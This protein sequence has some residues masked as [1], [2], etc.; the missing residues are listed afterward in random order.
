MTTDYI[1][2]KKRK[3]RTFFLKVVKQQNNVPRNQPANYLRSFSLK[4]VACSF[5]SITSLVSSWIWSVSSFLSD[6]SFSIR[7]LCLE[8]SSFRFDASVSAPCKRMLAFSN[9][10]CFS[11]STLFTNSLDLLCSSWISTSIDRD[12]SF[13]S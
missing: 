5:A 3:F 11:R 9:C 1:I 8:T 6:S 12:F 7:I 10:S 4:L 13:V 2:Q